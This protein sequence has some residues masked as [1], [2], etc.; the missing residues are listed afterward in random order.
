MPARPWHWPKRR[1]LFLGRA[2]HPPLPAPTTGPFPPL[3]VDSRTNNAL[4]QRAWYREEPAATSGRPVL[5]VAGG[6]FRGN[7]VARRLAGRRPK[8]NQGCRAQA[9]ITPMVHGRQEHQS[10]RPR[11]EQGPCGHEACHLT[12]FQSLGRGHGGP[13]QSI[14]HSRWRT[15]RVLAAHLGPAG[16]NDRHRLML[17]YTTASLPLAP[18][19]ITRP[20]A[21]DLRGADVSASPCLRLR[22]SLPRPEPPHGPDA[23]TR[24][25]DAVLQ[26]GYRSCASLNST[27]PP[28]R[29][30]RCADGTLED[31]LAL[32]PNSPRAPGR[33]GVPA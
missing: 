18:Q 6:P 17:V 5:T 27:I 13:S 23:P 4:F 20:S 32:E 30:R 21:A 10:T 15:R 2:S 16:L 31:I 29:P 1:P 19:L 12:G 11:H 22:A 9:S 7:N 25:V 28:W 8:K 24:S 33:P 26:D 3:P 14:L